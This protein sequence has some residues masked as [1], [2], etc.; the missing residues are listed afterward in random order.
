M[1]DL[2][3]RSYLTRILD[4][5]KCRADMQKTIRGSG[6]S[7]LDA[8]YRLDQGYIFCLA[9]VAKD[10]SKIANT[11]LPEDFYPDLSGF[12]DGEEGPTP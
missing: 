5:I 10:L 8:N 6:V 9:R 11:P 12:I 1:S 4:E 7:P 3:D 2:T